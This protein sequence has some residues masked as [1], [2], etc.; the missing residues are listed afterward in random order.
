ML[1]TLIKRYA[2]LFGL[3]S[4]MLST[5][6]IA[7]DRVA[8]EVAVPLVFQ[9]ESIGSVALMPTPAWVMVKPDE[10]LWS[11]AV[12]HTPKLFNPWQM[13]MSL[14]RINPVAFRH[15][16]ISVLLANSKLDMPSLRQLK[17]L[18]TRQAKAAYD[19]LIADY[20]SVSKLK[21]TTTSNV[22]MLDA[23]TAKAD[24]FQQQIINQQ[25][26]LNSLGSLSKALQNQVNEI[27]KIQVDAT[28][29]QELL[30]STSKNI[31][32]EVVIQ[33]Q[34]FKFL[35]DQRR[36]I[37]ADIEVLGDSFESSRAQLGQAQ[38]DL[39]QAEKSLVLT[40]K[41]LQSAQQSS[42][43]LD[44]AERAKKI[45]QAKIAQQIEQAKSK[46]AALRQAA[47]LNLEVLKSKETQAAKVIKELLEAKKAKQWLN[48]AQIAAFLLLLILI[49]FGVLWW[50]VAKEKKLTSKAKF[51]PQEVQDH[52]DSSSMSPAFNAQM[53]HERAT[54]SDDVDAMLLGQQSM[55]NQ[56]DE[57]IEYMSHEED[58]VTKLFLASSYK[59]MGELQ[60]ALEIL[61]EVTE[62]GDADQ[63]AQARVLLSSINKV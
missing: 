58:M 28:S 59:E 18:S 3:V 35:N 7:L 27:R 49:A 50:V 33:E 41:T 24:E 34:T 14:Y 62:K 4:I 19:V 46:E 31:A 15:G 21:G 44:Q 1:F 13:V 29:K 12:R 9:V 51:R 32:R 23:Q 61:Q 25:D 57:P 38:E 55:H 30:A 22:A 39:Y 47:K 40:Q 52:N 2:H 36:K 20:E 8:D 5:N 45:K 37:A 6:V 10:T 60:A 53:N 54:F 11:I 17:R 42:L 56:A 26:A 48:T 16:N 63:Q 43:L